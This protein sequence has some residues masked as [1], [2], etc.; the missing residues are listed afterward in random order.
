MAY[1][2]NIKEL[3]F[4]DNLILY[5]QQQVLICMCIAS[6]LVTKFKFW[7]YTLAKCGYILYCPMNILM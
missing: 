3:G 5:L 7:H 6:I 1:H 4:N 2:Y